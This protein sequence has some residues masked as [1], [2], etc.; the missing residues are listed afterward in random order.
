MSSK[1]SIEINVIDWKNGQRH[2]AIFIPE[3]DQMV[4]I[5][6]ESARTMAFH[7]MECADFIEPPFKD[8]PLLA[9]V[10]HE[11]SGDEEESFFGP[12]LDDDENEENQYIDGP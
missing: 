4:A 12:D 3:L 10:S 2:V 5:T 6:A 11:L 8:T 1:Q 7:L 9:G